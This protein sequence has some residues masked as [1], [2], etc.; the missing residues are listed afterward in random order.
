MTL[1]EQMSYR[2]ILNP[3][4]ALAVLSI[5]TFSLWAIFIKKAVAD[6]DFWTATLFMWIFAQ[7]LFCFTIPMFVKEVKNISR[8]QYWFILLVAVFDLIGTLAANRAYA[9][10][11]IV[12]SAII[13]LPLSAAIAFC[14]SFFFTKSIEKHTWRV[15][16]FRFIGVILIIWAGIKLG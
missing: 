8:S 10:N 3:G 12:S 2:S 7:I 14:I 9:A 4:I 1:D 16:L 15:Y 13:N 5:F 6:S 11:V